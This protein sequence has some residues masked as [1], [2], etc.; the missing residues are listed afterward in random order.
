MPGAAGRLAGY[1]RVKCLA[2]GGPPHSSLYRVRSKGTLQQ[3]ISRWMGANGHLPHL[4]LVCHALRSAVAGRVRWRARRARRRWRRWPACPTPPPSG[5]W[6]SWWTMCWSGS[7]RHQALGGRA[8]SGPV[9]PLR[10][11]GSGPREAPGIGGS[12]SAPFSR[13]YNSPLKLLPTGRF[14]CGSLPCVRAPYLQ[15]LVI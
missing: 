10:G 3:M 4:R 9:G 13:A 11:L 2:A 7:T 8:L 12:F 1:E 6:S 15:H 14:F 5:R